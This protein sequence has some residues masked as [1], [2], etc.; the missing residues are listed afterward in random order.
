MGYAFHY[1]A[2]QEPA[3]TEIQKNL[4]QE[5][6]L[7]TVPPETSLIDSEAD[8]KSDHAMVGSTYRTKLEFEEIRKYYDKELV[9]EGWRFLKGTE[10]TVKYNGNNYEL[11]SLYYVKGDYMVWIENPGMYDK[12]DTFAVDFTWGLKPL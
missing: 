7:I 3:V 2:S 4:K 11:R 8:H 1:I 12:T 10:K 5:F 9:G 6:D